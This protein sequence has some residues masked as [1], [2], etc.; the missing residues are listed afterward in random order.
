MP[1]LGSPFPDAA[2]TQALAV[3]DGDRS[4][5]VDVVAGGLTL[6][7]GAGTGFLG[8]PIGWAPGLSRA[9]PA[10]TSTATG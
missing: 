9:S 10:A 2:P 8:N 3:G 5:T 4:G 7:R 6:R 1:A